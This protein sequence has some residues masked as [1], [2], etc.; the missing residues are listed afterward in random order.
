[1]FKADV[2]HRVKLLEKQGFVLDEGQ[3]LYVKE[4]TINNVHVSEIIPLTHLTQIMDFESFLQDVMDRFYYRISYEVNKSKKK[5][6]FSFL[7]N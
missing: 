1:M 5:K 2:K 4:V 6:Q 3:K 7:F